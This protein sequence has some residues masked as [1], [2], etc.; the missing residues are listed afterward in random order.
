MTVMTVTMIMMMMCVIMTVVMMIMR[1]RRS[2][3][4]RDEGRALLPQ[5]IKAEQHDQRVS[6]HFDGARGNVH[7]ARGR[8]EYEH[9]NADEQH[10]DAGLHEG[11]DRGKKRAALPRRVVRNHV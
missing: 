7:V 10:R 8:A 3:Q 1:I 2:A 6:D 5:E 9:G 4:G 11:R